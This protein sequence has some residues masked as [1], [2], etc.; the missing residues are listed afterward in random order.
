VTLDPTFFVVDT[1][2]NFILNITDTVNGNDV[3][4]QQNWTLTMNA[5]PK[6]KY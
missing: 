6:S 1:K 3:T 4:V 2:Y 5:P